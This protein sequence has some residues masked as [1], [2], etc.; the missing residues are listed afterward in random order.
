MRSNPHTLTAYRAK[1]WT[2]LA[3]G[4]YG[5]VLAQPAGQL[6]VK[7]SR[8]DATRTYLEWVIA[9]TLAGEFMAGMPWIESL[10]DVGL[11]SYVV[12]MRRYE[13]KEFG[14][15]GEHN[16]RSNPDDSR[17]PLYI[18][19]LVDALRQDTGIY[20]DD[21]HLGNVLWDAETQTLIVT[22]PSGSGYE[23]SPFLP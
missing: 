9:K 11:G 23:P 4:A 15:W 3:S 21:M 14:W 10:T 7:K 18:K 22:D 5:K 2:F 19:T 6:V 8:N 13:K 12:V 17:C 1:G 16:W 20:A